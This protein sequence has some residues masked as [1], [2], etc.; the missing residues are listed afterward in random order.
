MLRR[1]AEGATTITLPSSNPTASDLRA[2]L[3]TFERL[4][5]E[6]HVALDQT[7]FTSTVAFVG[8]PAVTSEGTAFESGT[9]DTVPFRFSEPTVFAGT[10]DLTQP[11]R[12]TYRILGITRLDNRDALLLEPIRL[13][14]AR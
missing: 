5:P 13:E 12:L 8:T 11:L 2:L 4:T 1:E 6:Q 9:I 3:D 7:T 14:A 10:F